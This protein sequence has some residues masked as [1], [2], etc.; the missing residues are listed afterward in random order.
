MCF[1]KSMKR[2]VIFDIVIVTVAVS[3]LTLTLVFKPQIGAPLKQGV[4][5]IWLGI[6][7]IYLGV[8]FLMS[9]FFSGKSAVLSALMWLC[10]SFS[11]PRSR[12]MA[13][14]Y[15]VLCLAVGVLALLVGLGV[16]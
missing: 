4:A 8:L 14:F 15:F 10:E 3:L 7:I 16:L 1:G 9:Y 2:N 13:L 5:A 11:R 12:H 6:Y